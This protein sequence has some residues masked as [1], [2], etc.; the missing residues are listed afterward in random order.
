MTDNSTI[1]VAWLDTGRAP[2]EG[3]WILVKTGENP[4]RYGWVSPDLASNAYATG[5][6]TDSDP[7]LWMDLEPIPATEGHGVV[8]SADAYRYAVRIWGKTPEYASSPTAYFVREAWVYNPPTP[9]PLMRAVFVRV[10][11][12]EYVVLRG[13]EAA[14]LR[15]D[16]IPGRVSWPAALTGHLVTLSVPQ[17][18]TTCREYFNLGRAT[19]RKPQGGK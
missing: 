15:P 9:Q 13:F 1:G 5:T 3:A 8:L 2:A 16:D 17:G 19:R 12:G 10:G 7:I 6:L 4:N 18:T 14:H 11:P